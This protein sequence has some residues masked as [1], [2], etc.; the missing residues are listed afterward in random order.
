MY[1]V[2]LKPVGRL[3]R[4]LAGVE[5]AAQELLGERR[6]AVWD[7][8]LLAEQRDLCGAAVFAV[9]AGG[10]QAGG[11]GADDHDPSWIHWPSKRSSL[12]PS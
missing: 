8:G 11:A 5:F 1:V 9:G 3:D 12:Y 2:L 6:T 10:C 7:Q 4:Q